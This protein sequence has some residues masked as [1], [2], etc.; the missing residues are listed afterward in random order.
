[1]KKGLLKMLAFAM[2]AF[3]LL[4]CTPKPPPPDNPPP[5]ENTMTQVEKEYYGYLENP[6]TLPLS[7][8]YNDRYYKGLS[9]MFFAKQS[10]TAIPVAGGTKHVTVYK[11][12]VL[13]VTLES[14]VYPAYSAYDYTVYFNN[15]S[16]EN[17][18]VIRYL[19]A[20]DTSYECES[21]RLKGIYGDY[22]YQYKPY[23]FDLTVQPVDFVST[24]GRATHTYFP[25]FNHR[26]LLIY[27]PL[28]T[29]HRLLACPY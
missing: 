18:G 3:L 25:Y 11:F 28:Q 20:I 19:N 4:G 17:S 26:I 10:Q 21:A 6:E 9:P 5:E 7:F 8:V 12:D 22:D 29:L 2:S 27:K 15:I 16:Q 1:M 23:D 14:A 13:E 24:K